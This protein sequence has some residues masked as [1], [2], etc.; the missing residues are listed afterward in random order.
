M[1]S[2]MWRTLESELRNGGF[3]EGRH[4]SVVP[5]AEVFE[6]QPEPFVHRRKALKHL[7]A[8]GAGLGLLGL[9][10]VGKKPPLEIG[11]ALL[12]SLELAGVTY[13][14]SKNV[15]YDNLHREALLN[16]SK[17]EEKLREHAK[18]IRLNEPVR[19]AAFTI[20]GGQ[21]FF[22]TKEARDHLLAVR[23]WNQTAFHL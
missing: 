7:G 4:Y 8:V 2:A 21:I 16:L 19:G 1:A 6:K 10:I 22:L 9:G 23:R 17:Q 13:H 15:K 18:T 12:L 14:I 3:Q 5:A 20:G 11:G